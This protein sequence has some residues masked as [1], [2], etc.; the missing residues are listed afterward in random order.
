MA[1]A[2]ARKLLTGWNGLSGEPHLRELE[3]TQRVAAAD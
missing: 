2:D 3:P 1:L